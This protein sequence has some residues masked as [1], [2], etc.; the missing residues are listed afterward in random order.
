MLDI[1]PA[2]IELTI[3]RTP[4]LV[5]DIQTNGPASSN[6]DK[7]SS[8]AYLISLVVIGKLDHTDSHLIDIRVKDPVHKPNRRR[9]V[10]VLS[11]EFHMDLP[12]AGFER[13]YLKTKASIDKWHWVEGA[14][15]DQAVYLLSLGP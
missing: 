1:L 11:G 10:R 4:S 2:T 12:A 7:S 3:H 6:R 9:F 13:S 15:D 8:L 5:D 14:N